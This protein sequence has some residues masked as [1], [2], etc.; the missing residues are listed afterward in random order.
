MGGASGSESSNDS[1][2]GGLGGGG[3]VEHCSGCARLSVPL[4]ATTDHVHFAI[5][6]P[7]AT[8]LTSATVTLR[9]ALEAGAG[10]TI[11]MYVQQGSPDFGWRFSN[12]IRLGMLGPAM[13]SIVWNV[14]DSTGT[15]DATGIE[16]IGIQVDGAGGS[17]YASPSVILVDSIVVTGSSLASGVFD[18][19][20]ASSV[21]TT[22][23]ASGPV[24][25]IW[26]N[27]YAVDTNMADAAISWVG[28]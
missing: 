11:S 4:A 25:T 9:L 26:L 23:T 8:D 12:P 27:N 21:Y 18:F 22:K 28:P 13:Q 5:L 24:E 14:K 2:A 1:G 17:P 20:S 15:P 7:A 6:L 10:G 19:D 16:R 3:V